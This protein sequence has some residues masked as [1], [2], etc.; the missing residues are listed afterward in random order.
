MAFSGRP[1]CR[2]HS[3]QRQTVSNDLTLQDC[4]LLRCLLRAKDRMDAASQEE[5]TVRRMA[6]VSGV[7]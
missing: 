2:L 1:S 7:S 3:F 6:H 4:E 5:W